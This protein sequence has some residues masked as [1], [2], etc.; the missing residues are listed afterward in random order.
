MTDTKNK[1]NVLGLHIEF[2]VDNLVI[3]KSILQQDGIFKISAKADKEFDIYYRGIG[4][5]NTYV[6]TIKPTDN[7]TVSLTFK[8]PKDYKKHF[9]KAVCPKCNKHDQTVPIRY[10]LESTI[11]IQHVDSKGD[12]TLIPYDNKYYYDGGCV[13][14]DINP[15]Y[16]CKR[17]K[18]K[19]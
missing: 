8:V 10:G 18:V 13:T 6:Q 16:F 4:V 15:K 19:F 5:E 2:R 17:D 1:D 9:G 7:D 3:A 12:T 14:S 11:V